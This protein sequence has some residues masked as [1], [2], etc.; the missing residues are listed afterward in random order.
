MQCNPREI[1]SRFA[2]YLVF[3][4]T[5][6][7]RCVGEMCERVMG[8]VVGGVGAHPIATLRRSCCAWPA[9]LSSPSPCRLY[10]YGK[11]QATNGLGSVW[12]LPT[13]LLTYLPAACTG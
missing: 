11:G 3:T 10:V 9:T 2:G 7:V 13:Y 5:E 8:N 12:N 1:T 6:Q 4:I